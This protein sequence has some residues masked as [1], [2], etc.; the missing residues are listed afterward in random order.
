M[1]SRRRPLRASSR[2]V[3]SSISTP[4]FVA[5]T[6]RA[7]GNDSPSRFM[8]KLKMSPPS[9]QP[10][11]FHESRAGVT[12]N[13]AELVLDFGS[14]ADRQTDLPTRASARASGAPDLHAPRVIVRLDHPDTGRGLSSLDKPDVRSLPPSRLPGGID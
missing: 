11:H 12:V 13:D 3:L 7:S 4:A 10:K 8:T 6:L 9:P 2:D 5:R 1:T 14:N